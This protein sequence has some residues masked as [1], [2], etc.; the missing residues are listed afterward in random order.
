[1][2]KVRQTPVVLLQY[3]FQSRISTKGLSSVTKSKT[4]H[5]NNNNTVEKERNK[6]CFM[7]QCEF[8]KTLNNFGINTRIEVEN[9]S[10]EIMIIK[11]PDFNQAT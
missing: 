10:N 11:M 3:W 2:K 4:K 9:Q 6:D 5:N 8:P 1:M 7:V